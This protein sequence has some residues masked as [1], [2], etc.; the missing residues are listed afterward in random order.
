MLQ[1]NLFSLIND[2]SILYAKIFELLE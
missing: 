1:I 2:K